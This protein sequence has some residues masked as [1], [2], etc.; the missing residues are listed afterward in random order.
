VDDATQLILRQLYTLAATIDDDTIDEHM[1]EMCRHSFFAQIHRGETLTQEQIDAASHAFITLTERLMP[2]KLVAAFIDDACRM[3][4]QPEIDEADL[5][6][7]FT[8]DETMAGADAAL[9]MSNPM[10]KFTQ[11]EVLVCLA[12]NQAAP[13]IPVAIAHFISLIRAYTEV[14]TDMVARRSEAAAEKFVRFASQ[15]S[16]RNLLKFTNLALSVSATCQL[17]TQPFVI[18]QPLISEA[19]DLLNRSGSFTWSV[20]QDEQVQ[21]IDVDR[22]H[23]PAQ[24]FL[25][26][27]IVNEQSL[28]GVIDFV[29]NE[30]LR[31]PCAPELSRSLDFMRRFAAERQAEIS[32]A[33]RP[34]GE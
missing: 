27:L 1:G 33:S 25:H 2:P 19:M 14:I 18:D 15:W 24:A 29:K 31:R 32:H 3:Q 20:G 5:T 34:T 30:A 9:R 11:A 6:P 28:L 26:K 4:L 7:G 17:Q 8:T 10:R 21:Q 16:S 12:W 13:E 23:C 22:I